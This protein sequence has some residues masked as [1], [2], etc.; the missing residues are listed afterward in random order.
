M[1]RRHALRHSYVTSSVEPAC[2]TSF[3]SDEERHAGIL[4]DTGSE[5]Y[6]EQACKAVSGKR[7]E[8]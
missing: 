5:R 8:I 6:V 4:L 7:S 1:L 3:I 2:T